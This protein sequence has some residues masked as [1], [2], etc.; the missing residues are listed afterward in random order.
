MATLERGQSRGDIMAVSFESW[1]DG[2]A[3]AFDSSLAEARLFMES[4]GCAH[5]GIELDLDAVACVMPLY[6]VVVILFL[7]CNHQRGNIQTL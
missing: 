4:A 5:L 6:S 7:S 1:L 3:D 2:P